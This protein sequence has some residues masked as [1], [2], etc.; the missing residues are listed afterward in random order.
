M[1]RAA[2]V[3]FALVVVLCFIAPIAAQER[4]GV[5]LMHGKWGRPDQHIDGLARALRA[6]NVLVTTPLMPWG[7]GRDY[8]ADY[9][10][11]LGEIDDE[12][13]KLK[14][15]G[16]VTIVVAGLSLGANAALAYAASG[17]EVSGIVALAPGHTPER[18]I[19]RDTVA[20]SVET[21]RR[22][23]S[24]G[25]GD[26]RGTF[27]DLN[28]G[29][30]APVFTTPH[31]YLSYF[32]PDGMASMRRSVEAIKTPVPLLLVIGT[33]DP[34]FR[35][36]EDVLYKKVPPHPKSRYL[37][38]SSDHTGTPSAATTEVVDWILALKK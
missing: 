31:I 38:V 32:D 6:K 29:R 7:R 10:H 23:V 35:F 8:D 9:P 20:T 28:Q 3:V 1:A 36:A 30:T 4:I 25:K 21:A 12:I 15:Q 13:A 11:A 17:K 18:K 14:A 5:V 37:V 16:A 24:E 26:E 2:R 27:Q 19:F 33:R 34:L 22:M